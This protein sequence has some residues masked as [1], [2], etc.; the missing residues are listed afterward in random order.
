MTRYNI[1]LAQG[2]TLVC[3]AYGPDAT[4]VRLLK[5]MPVP[6]L[7]AYITPRLEVDPGL[8]ASL[9]RRTEQTLEVSETVVIDIQDG[10]TQVYH[11]D[12][13]AGWTP[14]NIFAKELWRFFCL[15]KGYDFPQPGSVKDV[16]ARKERQRKRPFA[17]PVEDDNG[18]RI[19]PLPLSRYWNLGR[20]YEEPT[21]TYENGRWAIL[22]TVPGPKGKMQTGR[23]GGRSLEE[24][25]TVYWRYVRHLRNARRH[26]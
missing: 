11:G 14:W 21:P 16:W 18:Q 2:F 17:T 23:F 7:P 12:D 1:H 6:F 22:A 19:Q 9:M 25:W 20:T 15:A 8:L 5:Q 24:A 3:L 4:A 10:L 13:E 26:P